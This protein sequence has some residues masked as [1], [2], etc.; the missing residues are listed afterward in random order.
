MVPT[1]MN[2]E[3]EVDRLAPQGGKP[4]RKYMYSVQRT[5]IK[6][7][8]NSDSDSNSNPAACGA[9]QE[10]SSPH[11]NVQGQDKAIPGGCVAY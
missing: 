3:A 7:S 2:N 5:V 9:E 6:E 1:P 11:L 8:K 4:K 10:S